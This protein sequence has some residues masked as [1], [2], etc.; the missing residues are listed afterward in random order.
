MQHVQEAQ[1]QCT[2][3]LLKWTQLCRRVVQTMSVHV[4][5]QL[6]NFAFLNAA[7]LNHYVNNALDLLRLYV[8]VIRSVQTLVRVT[9]PTTQ[10][11]CLLG[12]L[13]LL[14]NDSIVIELKNSSANQTDRQLQAACYFAINVCECNCVLRLEFETW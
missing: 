13:D 8:P 6:T 7:C 9:R 10:G 5:N 3:S 12:E 2:F 1:T 14:M 4:Q 11:P